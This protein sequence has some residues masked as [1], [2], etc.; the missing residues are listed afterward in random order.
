MFV[1]ILQTTN[2][3]SNSTFV[4]E[5]HVGI[6]ETKESKVVDELSF[7]HGLCLQASHGLGATQVTYYLP[8]T[9]I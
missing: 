8:T 6:K 7:Y 5:I 9:D 4:M 3:K 2:F 1:V